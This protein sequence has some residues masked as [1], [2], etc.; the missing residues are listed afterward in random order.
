MQSIVCSVMNGLITMDL[1]NDEQNQLVQ[2]VTKFISNTRP[3]ISNIKKRENVRNITLTLLQ[4]REME[5]FW[6]WN[7][8]ITS[9]WWLNLIRMFWQLHQNISIGIFNRNFIGS[10]T[11]NRMNLRKGNQNTST[12]TNAAKIV[13]NTFISIYMKIVW[14]RSNK[15]STHCIKKTNKN[16]KTNSKTVYNNLPN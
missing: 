13:D 2:K 4:G 8:F 14:T 1:A 11:S 6:N 16:Q 9:T 3:K 5:D 7:N 15:S 10:L 12:K